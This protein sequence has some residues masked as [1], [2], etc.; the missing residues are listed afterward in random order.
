MKLFQLTLLVYLGVLAGCASEEKR[1][2]FDYDC[3]ERCHRHGKTDRDCVQQ[4]TNQQ[5]VPK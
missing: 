2:G 5:S 1:E 4:C 3:F